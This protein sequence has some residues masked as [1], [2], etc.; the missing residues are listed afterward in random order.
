[1]TRSSAPEHAERINAALEL[2]KEYDSPAKAAA[3]VAVRFG[4]SRSQAYRYVRKAGVMSEKMVVPGHKIP[5]TIKLSQD[6]I[7]ALREYA[8]STGKTLSEVVTQALESFLRG[9]QGR[10]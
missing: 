9:I 1:M 4:I 5:F 10:G 2:L 7:Q 8:I 6:L 3:E